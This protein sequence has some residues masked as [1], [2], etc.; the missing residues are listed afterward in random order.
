MKHFFL[1]V[2]CVYVLLW[3]TNPA[4][5]C[6]IPVFRYAM[7]RWPADYYEGIVIHKGPLADDNPAAKL[8]QG[9]KAPPCPPGDNGKVQEEV[10]S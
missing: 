5:A 2:L 10:T 9:E 3:L 4:N 6:S 1:L 7:E 8:L